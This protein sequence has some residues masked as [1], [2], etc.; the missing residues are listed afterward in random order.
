MH[1]RNF[2]NCNEL[3]CGAF[4][5]IFT[6]ADEGIAIKI[7]PVCSGETDDDLISTF[8]EVLTDL[9]AGHS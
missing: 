8:E 1:C 2:F 4:D 6:C 9:V 5:E 3:W 7:A